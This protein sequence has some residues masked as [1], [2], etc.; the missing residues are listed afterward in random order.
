MDL[1]AL[2][3]GLVGR[4]ATIVSE[5]NTALHMGSGGVE[6][7][8]TP[9]M[10]ALMEQAAIN[11]I[12]PSLPPGWQSVGVHID[13]R[14]IAA[15]PLG[16]GVK[17]EAELRQVDGRRLVFDVKAWDDFELIGQGDHE[18]VVIDL[19]RFESRLASKRTV[20]GS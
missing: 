12:A 16:V 15:S 19:K 17:A 11:A 6:V 7:F 20:I 3:P 5:D 4:S 9:A 8:A 18:R 13:V 2:E 10:V 1:A 14:H